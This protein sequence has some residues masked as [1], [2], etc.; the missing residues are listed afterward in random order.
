MTVKYILNSNNLKALM[1]NDPVPQSNRNTKSKS[2]RDFNYSF[3]IKKKKFIELIII[4]K[5]KKN[6]FRIYL[7]K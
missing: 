5:V 7:N 1:G 6:R 3:I 4:L 2:Q